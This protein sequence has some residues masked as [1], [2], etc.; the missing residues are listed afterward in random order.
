MPGGLTRVA[1][2]RG[3]AG[4]E[5]VAGR[6]QQGYLG[7]E[8]VSDRWRSRCFH[9]SPTVLYWMSRY[10]ERAEHTTRLLDVNLNLMLDESATQRRPALAAGAAGAGQARRTCKWKGDPY[11]LA[12][13]LTFDTEYQASILSCIIC[14]ARECAPG[15]RADLHRAV[16][17][18][19]PPLSAG[20][21]AGDAGSDAGDALMAAPSSR[22]SFCS[23]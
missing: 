1:L 14:G 8:P 12:Q 19:E 20:H 18:A 17:A 9:A 15:A 10:L 6:R 7:A 5:L 2:K 13:T 21:A 22:R 3:L 23:R 16:A 11:A 4:G